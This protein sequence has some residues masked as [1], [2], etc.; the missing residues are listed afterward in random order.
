MERFKTAGTREIEAYEAIC[1]LSEKMLSVAKG[2][3][4]ESI[5]SIEKKRAQ[6]IQQVR[7]LSKKS[8]LNNDAVTR[9]VD[10]IQRILA[11]DSETKSCVQSR[12]K[13]LKTGFHTERTLLKTYGNKVLS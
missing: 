4:W 2:G 13:Q 12:M 10:L 9:K 7:D 5:A 1:A 6:L 11:A 8:L 3:E